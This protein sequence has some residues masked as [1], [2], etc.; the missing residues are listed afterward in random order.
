MRPTFLIIGAQKS[1]TTTLYRDLL[2]QPGVFFPL[3]KEPT[4]LAHDRVLSPEGLA[5]YEAMY[6]KAKPTDARGD[7]STGYTRIPRFNGAPQRAM[8]VLGPD[9]QLL[10]IIREPISRIISHHHHV[11]TNE[12]APKT[13][14]EFLDAEWHTL[15]FS[16]Y[17]YQAR[18]WLDVYPRE[19]LHILIFEEY[20]RKRREEIERLGPLLKFDPRPDR[21]D[22]ESRFNTAEDRSADRGLAMRIRKSWAY[23]R[24]RPLLTAAAR[25]RLRRTF[26][27]KAPPPPPPPSSVCIERI[28][29][30]LED[31]QRELA[32]IIGRP[33]PIWDPDKVRRKYAR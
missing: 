4:C 17:A 12:P 26:S 9:I 15:T 23:Q 19:R 20:V 24:V 31:D 13:V 8:K 3:E 28:L 16:R 14:D 29:R 10:Y 2:T 22:P 11:I 25:D 32:A 33:Y 1:G 30:E 21:I 6:A 18:A 27:A 7:A 5:E